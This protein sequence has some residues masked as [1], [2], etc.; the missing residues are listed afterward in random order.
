MSRLRFRHLHLLLELERGGSLRAAAQSLNL[1]Q[2]AL[3]K[4]LA[5]IESAFAAELFTRTARGLTPTARGRAALRGATLLLGELA[6]MRQEVCADEAVATVVR[7]GAPPFVAHGMLPAVLSQLVRQQNRIRV[8]VMEERVPLLL[9]ALADGRVDAL[10][11]SYPAQMPDDLGV[12]MR[13]ERLSDTEFCVVAPARH[14]LCQRGRVDWAALAK[15]DWIMPARSSMVRR[16]IEESFVCAGLSPPIPLVES[17]SPVTNLQLV[18]AGL[19]VTAV[20]SP[21]A[22]PAIETGQVGQVRVSPA[23]PPRPVALIYRAGV[24][25]PRLD[26]VRSAL[27]ASGT[28]KRAANHRSRR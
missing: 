20:P 18:A 24:S 4:A 1:T 26:I 3:S 9:Q 10:I 8:E 28:R 13:F 16:L 17:T 21:T 12:E 23:L 19:G 5:E 2:P 15:H 6:H 7:V 14:P 27:G 11:T 25:N 22:S